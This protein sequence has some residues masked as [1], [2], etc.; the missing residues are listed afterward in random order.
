[1]VDMEQTNELAATLIEEYEWLIK[2]FEIEDA[3]ID[4][5]MDLINSWLSFNTNDLD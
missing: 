4:T 2:D 1:M 5:K 3:D